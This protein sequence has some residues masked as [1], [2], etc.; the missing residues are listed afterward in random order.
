[1]AV[2][3]ALQCAVVK[4]SR[5]AIEWPQGTISVLF[6]LSLNRQAYDVDEH[7]KFW[8]GMAL[9]AVDRSAL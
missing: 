2:R 9:I 8:G 7:H 6:T 3:L 1:V 5:A 4:G